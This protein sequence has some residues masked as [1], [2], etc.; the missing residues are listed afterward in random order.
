MASDPPPVRLGALAENGIAP[1]I[2]ALVEHGAAKR[3]DIARAAHGE[4]ELRFSEGYAPVRI[5]FLGDEILVED[6]AAPDAPDLV[7]AGSLPD[8]VHLTA[9]PLVGGVPKPTDARGRTALA[10]L[11]KGRVRL[12]GD[13]L[14]GRR[15]LQVLAL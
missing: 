9:V 15:L 14:L 2:F 10:R 12:D 1:S 6:G 13:R 4:V 7:I 5:A 11:A 3:P 8:V